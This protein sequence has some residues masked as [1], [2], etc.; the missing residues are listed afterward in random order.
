MFGENM[1]KKFQKLERKIARTERREHPLYGKQRI[2][3]IANAAAGKVYRE[4]M[5]K[6]KGLSGHFD[7]RC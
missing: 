3:Y 6:K 2:Q 5:A 1:G 7:G 4:K